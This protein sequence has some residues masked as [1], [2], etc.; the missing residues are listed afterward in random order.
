MTRQN[1]R[2]IAGRSRLLQGRA[3]HAS[4]EIAS[5]PARV[6]TARQVGKLIESLTKATWPSQ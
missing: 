4:A 5:P 3:R 6:E 2:K 1:A